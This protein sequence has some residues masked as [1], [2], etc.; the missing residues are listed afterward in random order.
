MNCQEISEK[1][2]TFFVRVFL[3]ALVIHEGNILCENK[4]F[5]HQNRATCF[6]LLLYLR[7]ESNKNTS[8]GL[9]RERFRFTLLARY[10]AGIIH[11]RRV[12]K[13]AYI[14]LGDL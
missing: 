7:L 12:K 6:N 14:N 1:C 11:S 5:F 9:G 2:S 10:F 8:A 4:I 13:V 3:M